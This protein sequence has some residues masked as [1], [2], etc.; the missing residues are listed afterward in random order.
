M[1]AASLFTNE[2][3]WD[4]VRQFVQEG[5]N[6]MENN[7]LLDFDEVFDKLERRYSYAKNCSTSQRPFVRRNYGLVAGGGY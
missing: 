2:L 6:D 5:L 3:T 1:E 4:E 7:R